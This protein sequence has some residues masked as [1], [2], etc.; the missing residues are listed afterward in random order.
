MRVEVHVNEER[1][2]LGSSTKKVRIDVMCTL[3]THAATSGQFANGFAPVGNILTAW[4]LH[5][6]ENRMAAKLEGPSGF[7]LHHCNNMGRSLA[8]CRRCVRQG[9]RCRRR[10]RR[11]IVD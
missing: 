1:I 6:D 4:T 8:R 5:G 11:G 10:R 3:G 7:K 2:R 9:C